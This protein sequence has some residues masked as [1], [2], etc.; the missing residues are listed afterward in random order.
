MWRS[1]KRGQSQVTC[2]ACGDDVPRS[3]AREYDKFGDRWDRQGKEFEYLCKPCDRDRCHQPRGDLE[4]LLED[5]ESN[6]VGTGRD[7]FL[8]TYLEL[9]EGRDSVGDR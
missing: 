7:A 4:A 5:V 9:T 3:D 8:A 2:I 1:S 6:T